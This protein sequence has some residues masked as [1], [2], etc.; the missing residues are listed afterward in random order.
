MT[1][2]FAIWLLALYYLIELSFLIINTYTFFDQL[3]EVMTT[4]IAVCKIPL[5]IISLIMEFL[6]LY[7]GL[8]FS[9]YLMRKPNQHVQR[10]CVKSWIWFLFSILF[11]RSWY[12]YAFKSIFIFVYNADQ[13]LRTK[14]G[15]YDLI[16]KYKLLDNIIQVIMNICP[17]LIAASITGILLYF[18]SSKDETRYQLSDHTP[19]TSRVH[20]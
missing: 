14:E 10:K 7:T 2:R 1:N 19:D 8:K 9:N 16:T 12:E 6:F 3:N 18:G 4:G 11:V 13:T 15:L 5:F 17:T 20:S